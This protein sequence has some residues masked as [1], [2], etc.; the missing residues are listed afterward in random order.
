MVL[1]RAFSIIEVVLAIVIIGL[2]VVAIPTIII[3]S[4]K[5]NTSA[6]KEEV[7]LTAKMQM[8]MILF[9]PW[10]SN[11]YKRTDDSTNLSKSFILNTSTKSLG[12]ERKL[13]ENQ[14]MS[15]GAGFGIIGSDNDGMISQVSA[16]TIPTT[17][18]VDKKGIESYNGY[19]AN[20]TS[21]GNGT[22]GRGSRDNI[23]GITA[24][25]TVSYIDDALNGTQNYTNTQAANFQ[26]KPAST[27]NI[28]NIKM[29]QIRAI[30][31]GLTD[32]D[33][34]TLH[35]FS[36]NVASPEILALP[37]RNLPKP[38]KTDPSRSKTIPTNGSI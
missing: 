3:Q 19:T 35:A 1:R 21:S 28:T 29:I 13:N 20:L 11:S 37:I 24:N 15:S 8:G 2:S 34:I 17:S 30:P 14:K 23:F 31:Q 7:I 38:T 25:V 26:F 10:D 12:L 32:A 4:S 9:A 36:S 16:S 5:A 6:L 27:S 33:S 22:Q 18:N